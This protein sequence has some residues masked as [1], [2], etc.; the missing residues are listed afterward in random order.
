MERFSKEEIEGIWNRYLAGSCSSEEEKLIENWHHA[1]LRDQQINP[2]EAE[3]NSVLQ[4]FA[5]VQKKRRFT[6]Y[7]AAASIV[8]I[9]GALMF[10]RPHRKS[11]TAKAIFDISKMDKSI[12]PGSNQGVFKTADG[13]IIPLDSLTLHNRKVLGNLQL[14][15]MEDGSIHYWSAS[16]NEEI[17]A[18]EVTTPRGG[19][20]HLTL[21][22]GTRVWLNASSSLKWNSGKKGARKVE[23]IGEA[24]F[25]VSKNKV[26]PFTVETKHSLVTV[27]GT[28]FNVSAYPDDSY[29]KA[30]LLEGSV[31]VA[32]LLNNKQVNSS[33]LKAGQ[34]AVVLNERNVNMLIRQVS[35]ESVVAWKNGLFSFENTDLNELTRQLERW[36]NLRFVRLNVSQNHAYVGTIERTSD[37]SDV[38]KILHLSG[39]DVQVVGRDLY[40]SDNK[41]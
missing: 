9:L 12:V 13:L 6:Y 35:V 11:E 37:L 36:Y 26:V 31:K 4:R 21:A 19:Q 24:Y 22:D 16:T 5:V 40:I 23:L 34:Q 10:F 25:E 3:L 27:Y 17:T 7:A 20:S 15:R 32:R 30:T 2:D 41:D 33:M 29:T 18:Y 14:E 8:L 28:H 1:M 39:L 38:L